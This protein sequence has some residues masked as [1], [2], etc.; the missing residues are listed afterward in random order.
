MIKLSQADH[1]TIDQMLRRGATR[2]EVMGWLG[3]AGLGLAAAGT[4]ATNATRALADT[5]KRGGQ[6]RVAGYSSSTADTLDPA[7]QT[8]STDYVRC[9]M[10]YNG[11]TTLDGNLTPQPALAESFDSD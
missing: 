4:I 6:I 1:S 5:P 10:F 9:N 7:K 3:S 8:L 11:L 2:R